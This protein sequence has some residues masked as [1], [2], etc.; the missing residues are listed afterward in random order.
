ME[1][2]AI[3]SEV[4]QGVPGAADR[5]TVTTFHGL[6]PNARSTVIGDSVPAPTWSS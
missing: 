3:L 6:G 5:L 2:T 4:Q 1:I